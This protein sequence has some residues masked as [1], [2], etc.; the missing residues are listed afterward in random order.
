MRTYRCSWSEKVS[1]FFDGEGSAWG[2]WLCG[3]H[4]RRC[5]ACRRWLR[6]AERSWYRVRAELRAPTDVAFIDAVMARVEGLPS[7]PRPAPA[8]MRAIARWPALAL[9]AA[10]AGAGLLILGAVVLPPLTS[11]R[12]LF[13]ASRCQSNLR[14]LGVALSVYAADYDDRL[15]PRDA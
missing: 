12:A 2:R 7:P 4:L 10:A 5:A 14:H 6:Q 3:Q 8:P 15:P 9:Q 13:L 11:S 1:A